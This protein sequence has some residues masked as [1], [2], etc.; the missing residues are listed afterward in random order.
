M[1]QLDRLSHTY[2]RRLSE[3]GRE[4]YQADRSES[5]SVHFVSKCVSVFFLW[6]IYTR[7][8]DLLV[9]SD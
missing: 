2:S 4:D 9:G 5:Q 7:Q 8:H 1:S 3:S 6:L